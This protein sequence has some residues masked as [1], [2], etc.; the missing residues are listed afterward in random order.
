VPKAGLKKLTGNIL[1]DLAQ[2][3]GVLGD[4]HCE[5]AAGW[6]RRREFLTTRTD[7]WKKPGAEWE[8]LLMAAATK[9]RSTD[10]GI[11]AWPQGGVNNVRGE[12]RMMLK[13]YAS[14]KT[15]VS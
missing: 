11:G 5:G 9:A 6:I 15:A 1:D 8:R 3:C 13:S 7:G 12:A 14:N 10:G 2:V 4:R